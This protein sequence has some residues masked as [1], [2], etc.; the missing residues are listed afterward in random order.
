MLRQK[1]LRTSAG[2]LT[3]TF[4]VLSNRFSGDLPAWVIGVM[5]AAAGT[6]GILW[7]SLSLEQIRVNRM[8]MAA[9]VGIVCGLVG[10]AA[11]WFV[12][13]LERAVS[14]S[15]TTTHESTNLTSSSF[16]PAS[17]APSM[18]DAGSALQRADALEDPA[19]E[20]ASPPVR[21]GLP[22]AEQIARALQAM[23]PAAMATGPF[24]PF[25]LGGSLDRAD[26][27]DFVNAGDGNHWFP[28]RNAVDVDID[29]ANFQEVDLVARVTVRGGS[30][31]VGIMEVANASVDT[32]KPAIDR[33]SKA[34][35]V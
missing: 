32:S 4:A 25:Q 35:I 34:A 22:S 15:A 29:W 16:A 19:R 21:S 27:M 8:L 10:S 2:V 9:F 11:Y 7:L 33:H 20:S 5:A 17:A 1:A 13:G 18:P 14:E 28:A 3:L 24:P 26:I 31:K 12:T 30:C 23:Q 6:A